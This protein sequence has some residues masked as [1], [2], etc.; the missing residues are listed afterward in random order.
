MLRPAFQTWVAGGL[1][2]CPLNLRALES[3]CNRWVGWGE[4]GLVMSSM[5]KP[6]Q[7]WRQKPPG[8]T[9]EQVGSEVS[10]RLARWIQIQLQYYYYCLSVQST[11]YILHISSS[12]QQVLHD[13]PCC[14]P[15][16]PKWQ[17]LAY[18]SPSNLVDSWTR[19]RHTLCKAT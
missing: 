6:H 13:T 8:E 3:G 19:P 4:Y 5:P 17:H 10:Q 11:E 14:S 1:I 18:P 12:N 15:H 7:T 9:F 16:V 2:L